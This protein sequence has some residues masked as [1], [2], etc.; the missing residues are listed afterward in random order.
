MSSEH[1]QRAVSSE[2]E[3]AGTESQGQLPVLPFKGRRG[4]PLRSRPRHTSP[5][6]QI[7]A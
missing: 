3:V 4:D 7:F 6:A 1:E 5:R 2:R